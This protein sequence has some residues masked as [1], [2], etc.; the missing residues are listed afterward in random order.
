MTDNSS[1]RFNFRNK[2]YTG[3]RF[4]LPRAGKTCFFLQKNRILGFEVFNVFKVFLGFN[5]QIA[6]T[7]LRPTSKDSVMWTPQIAIHIWISNPDLL[8]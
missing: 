6:N 2:N 3:H 7:K 5:L 8:A 4:L 1:S